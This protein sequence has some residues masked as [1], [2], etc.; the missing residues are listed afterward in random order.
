[1]KQIAPSIEKIS[2]KKLTGKE[3]A[4]GQRG[5]EFAKLEHFQVDDCCLTDLSLEWFRLRQERTG[6]IWKRTCGGNWR[7]EASRCPTIPS[8]HGATS[9]PGILQSAVGRIHH[10]RGRGHRDSGRRHPH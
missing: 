2:I 1:M 4:A 5:Y 8:H 9:R 7:F 10:V 6:V 3:P